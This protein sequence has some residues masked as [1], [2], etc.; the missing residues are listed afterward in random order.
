MLGGRHRFYLGTNT[1]P[2]Q[3]DT[4]ERRRVG[5]IRR[6]NHAA[7][8]TE[9]IRIGRRGARSL[10]S[11]YRMGTNKRSIRRQAYVLPWSPPFP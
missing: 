3:A 10:V 6:R 11:G 8:A 2:E 5:S 7:R 9:Q 1:L 4:L